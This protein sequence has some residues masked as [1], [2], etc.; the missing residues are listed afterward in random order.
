MLCYLENTGY[1]ALLEMLGEQ[2]A[3]ASR[4]ASHCSLANWDYLHTDVW[5]AM[6]TNYSIVADAAGLGIVLASGTSLTM[7]VV[8]A[9]LVLSILDNAADTFIPTDLYEAAG[10]NVP[11]VPESPACHL[12][13]HHD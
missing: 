2:P 4:T 5:S 13:G 6:A 1:F 12:A 10:P 7:P 9:R 8:A 3:T 11:A